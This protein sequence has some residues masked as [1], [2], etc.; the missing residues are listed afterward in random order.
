MV[1]AYKNL[2]EGF[3]EIQTCIEY[4]NQ[5]SLSKHSI[6]INEF[7]Q[8]VIESEEEEK[9]DGYKQRIH[10]LK[11][12]VKMRDEDTSSDEVQQAITLIQRMEIKEP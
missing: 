8:D 6:D 5:H 1:V 2:L 7:V 11:R 12:L 4:I 3:K 10:C 9:E